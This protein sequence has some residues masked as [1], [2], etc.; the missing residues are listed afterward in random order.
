M[1]AGHLS[2]EADILLRKWLHTSDL[3]IGKRLPSSRALAKLLDISAHAVRHAIT[4]LSAEGIVER[5]GYK[6]FYASPPLIQTDFHCDLLMHRSFLHLKTYVKTAKSLG[7]DLKVHPWD[8]PEELTSL[9]HQLD[10]PK[11]EGLL[12]QPP[13]PISLWEPVMARL[14]DHGIPIVSIC[15]YISKVPSVVFSYLQS[16]ELVFKHLKELGHSEIVR[17][18]NY[19]NGSVNNFWECLR[20]TI[21]TSSLEQRE[22]IQ[23]NL[24]SRQRDA[25]EL[26]DKLATEWNQVT[27]LIISWESVNILPYL[28]GELGRQKRQVPQDISIICMD[29]SKILQTCNPPI[30]GIASDEA[31]LAETALQMVQRIAL[32][33]RELGI[34]PPVSCIRIDQR[35]VLRSSTAAA[36]SFTS[37]VPVKERK[38]EHEIGSFSPEWIGNTKRLRQE[39]EFSL[40]RPY[41]LAAR[42]LESR[43][44]QMDLGSFVNRPLNFRRGWLGDMPLP[45]FPPGRHVIHGV[46]FQVLGGASRDD[47][48]AI[49]FHSSINTK[50]HAQSLPITLRIPI[51][52][53]ADA[54]YILHGCGY[55][56]F[57]QPFA[58]YSFYHGKK[59]IESIPLVTLGQPPVSYDPARLSAEPHQPNIQDWWSA[60]PQMNFSNARMAPIAEYDG[61]NLLRCKYLY[62]LEWINPSPKTTISHLEISVD[63]NQPITL[64]MLAVTIL[65]PIAPTPIS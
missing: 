48:G 55:T 29:D 31:L 65:R 18:L 42:S 64:G 12:F 41:C 44:A 51:D 17:V 24:H 14:F 11:T 32:K 34:M 13:V 50:S 30:S 57:L 39:L 28:L 36:P 27:A 37:P 3:H 6:L 35:L 43:F 20:R 58:T 33:K 15:Q 4:R 7:I 38:E 59:I 5:E 25:C 19:H 26:A 10:S 2:H 8:S 61:G 47:H 62:T 45:H 56:G 54:I 16:T 23:S 49:I 21:G 52:S 9:L 1:K 22:F 63:P 40:R 53:K 60:Y 46:P